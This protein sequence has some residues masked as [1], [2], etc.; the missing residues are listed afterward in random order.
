M[1]EP[2]TRIGQQL[3]FAKL[4]E[5]LRDLLGVRKN[6]LKRDGDL[7]YYSKLL[8]GHIVPGWGEDNLFRVEANQRHQLLMVNKGRNQIK[9]YVK[10][11]LQKTT[12]SSRA[13]K[14]SCEKIVALVNQLLEVAEYLPLDEKRSDDVYLLQLIKSKFPI[15]PVENA[16]PFSKIS[17][18][19]SKGLMA[20]VTRLVEQARLSYAEVRQASENVELIFFQ[21]GLP[22]SQWHQEISR[23]ERL[24]GSR[25]Y[26][27]P[28]L[29]T[30]A[31]PQS[32]R[33]Q[34]AQT[35]N[36]TPQQTE[37]YLISRQ[38]RFNVWRRQLESFAQHDIYDMESL[39]RELKERTFRGV[40]LNREQIEERVLRVCN[41]L[42]EFDNFQIGLNQSKLNFHFQVKADQFVLMEGRRDYPADRYYGL[43]GIKF[44]GEAYLTAFKQLFAEL[45]GTALSDKNKVKS[46]LREQV[47]LN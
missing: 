24:E 35:Q 2:E 43:F 36:W 11:L 4:A 42:D 40:R 20:E 47:G 18:E 27:G 26:Y 34:F 23:V 5:D 15:E 16:E 17:E 37:E 46:W 25:L 30:F 29:T 21:G 6:D 22:Q 44:S 9:N 38:R 19:L 31:T 14:P 12:L 13:E 32:L 33:E 45:W 7:T 8:N 39:S 28:Y 1:S 10:T 3:G 41:F